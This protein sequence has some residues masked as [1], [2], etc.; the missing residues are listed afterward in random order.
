MT[1]RY[2]WCEWLIISFPRVSHYSSC[3]VL[4][5]GM[6]YRK[7]CDVQQ[8]LIFLPSMSS[9]CTV[10]ML[11]LN[12]KPFLVCV[13]VGSPHNGVHNGKR[14]FHCPRGHGAMV[15]FCD[16]MRCNPPEK[17]PAVRGNYMFPSFTEVTTRRRTRQIQ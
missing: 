17:R 5:Y 3:Q 16:V 7:M 1:Y 8:I 13:P 14:F 6:V 15:R 12:I 4:K 10:L 11:E 9:P 2:K